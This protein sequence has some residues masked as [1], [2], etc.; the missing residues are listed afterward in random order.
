MISS[1]ILQKNNEKG[2]P[3]SE[4]I[5]IVICSR[6]NK[7]AVKWNGDEPFMFY[8]GLIRHSSKGSWGA[9]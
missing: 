6:G 4:K 3:V 7:D 8:M 1:E 2:K 9:L 5:S